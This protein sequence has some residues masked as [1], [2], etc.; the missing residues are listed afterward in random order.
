MTLLSGFS[1]VFGSLAAIYQ[2]FANKYDLVY[3]GRLHQQDDDQRIVR[4][5]TVSAQHSDEHYCVG[6]VHGYDVVLLKRTDSLSMMN[7][8]K[9]EKYTW[10]IM[11]FDL[12]ANYDLPHVFLD[13]GHHNEAFYQTLFIKFARL[14]KVDRSLFGED[15]SAFTTRFTA[16][17]P[18]DSLDDLP[19]LLAGEVGTTMAHHFAH[20]D[21]EWFQDRLIVYSTGHMP[22][23]H[24]LEHMLRAGL[25]MARVLD[26]SSQQKI[27]AQHGT[28]IVGEAKN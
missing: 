11:Q 5:I 17:T 19:V 13:G 3:F 15:M 24:L 8:S 28:G 22:T 4:G 18:P 23:K 16:Y 20:L 26:E 25:W 6:T 2:Y 14:M 10:V 27:P 12:H 9:V 21:F 1:K 7:S